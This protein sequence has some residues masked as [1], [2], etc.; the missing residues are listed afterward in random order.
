MF[1]LVTLCIGGF[2][3]GVLLSIVIG[4]LIA[5]WWSEQ[6]R[7]KWE[8]KVRM[9]EGLLAEMAQDDEQPGQTNGIGA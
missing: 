6:E 7:R 3:I 4:V 5:T 1:E 8:I 2:I 9:A